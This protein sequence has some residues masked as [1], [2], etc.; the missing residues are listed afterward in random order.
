MGFSVWQAQ[1][2]QTAA[3]SPEFTASAATTERRGK[4]T[5]FCTDRESLSDLLLLPPFPNTVKK[6]ALY[7]DQCQ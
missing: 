5:V 7:N 6:T 3:G 1:K 2:T 4:D